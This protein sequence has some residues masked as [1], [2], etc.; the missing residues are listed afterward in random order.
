MK[1]LCG[2]IINKWSRPIFKLQSDFS[3]LTREERINRDQEV[4]DGVLA[5]HRATKEREAN[6]AEKELKPGNILCNLKVFLGKESCN[7]NS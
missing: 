6:E 5:N 1:D 4:A 3:A 2:K 7:G